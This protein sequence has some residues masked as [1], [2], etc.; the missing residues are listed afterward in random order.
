M[1]LMTVLP[2]EFSIVENA[3]FTEPDDQSAW[4]YHQFLLTWAIKEIESKQGSGAEAEAAA[5]AGWLVDILQQQL[6]L[7]RSLYEIE[8]TCTWV[9]NSLV[10]MIT[11]LCSQP[12]AAAAAGSVDVSAPL[13]ERSELL[14]KLLDVDPNH[15]HRYKYL[16]LNATFTN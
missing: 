15:R 1:S 4:W 8:P 16:L 9:M 14:Q 11:L 13:A 12:L 2:A 7:V 6:E 10:A 5:L 3:I